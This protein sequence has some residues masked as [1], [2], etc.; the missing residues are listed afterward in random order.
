MSHFSTSAINFG[1]KN[2]GE[3]FAMVIC[4]Y[5][6]HITMGHFKKYLLYFNESKW[7]KLAINPFLNIK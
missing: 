2:I 3:K 6:V 1:A 5:N 7:R 4:T